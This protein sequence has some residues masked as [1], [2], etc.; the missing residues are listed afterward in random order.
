MYFKLYT[1]N[2]NKDIL[3]YRKGW[4]IEKVYLFAYGRNKK[5]CV[6]VIEG[7]KDIN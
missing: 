1:S 7:Y 2:R 6:F 4:A 5:F 3:R